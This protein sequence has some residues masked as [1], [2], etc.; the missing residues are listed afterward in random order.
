MPLCV[1]LLQFDLGMIFL[2]MVL[3]I[4]YHESSVQAG[5]LL[6]DLESQ[7]ILFLHWIWKSLWGSDLGW[8]WTGTFMS[9]CDLAEP[10][11]RLPVGWDLLCVSFEIRREGPASSWGILISWF[12]T[13]MQK[14]SQLPK[15]ILSLRWH[16]IFQHLISQNKSYGQILQKAIQGMWM[17]SFV[18]K[19]TE[20]F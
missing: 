13:S 3:F 14:A 1:N 4:C 2:G 12:I 10:T 8:V 6:S 5:G 16:Q 11:S 18:E 15:C 20:E 19:K 7:S 17:C 9:V